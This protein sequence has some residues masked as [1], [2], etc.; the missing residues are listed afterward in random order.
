[1]PAD[2]FTQYTVA[3]P[4]YDDV[5]SHYEQ[6]TAALDA[7]ATP[8]EA[9]DVVCRWDAL[10]RSL[11]T[12]ST[13]VNIR[14]NQDTRNPDYITAREYSDEIAPKL[15]NLAVD[16]K[17]RLMASP[18]AGAI[19]DRVGRQ[20]FDLWKCDLASFDPII[21]EDLVRQSQLT[22][23]YTSLLAS[24]RFEF[25][26]ES[27][28][29]SEIIKFNEHPRRETRHA[30]ARTHWGWFTENQAQ[31]DS[32]FDQLVHLRDAMAKKL[33]Y[34]DFIGL[35][36]QRMQRVDYDQGDVERFRAE[37]REHVVPLAAEI[38][39]RQSAKL[40]ID[41]LMAWDEALHDPA[42]NPRPAG[43]HDWMIDRA[44]RMFADLSPPMRDF[45]EKM[46]AT[47]TMDLESRE[48]KAGGGFCDILPDFGMS[49]I[50]A[51]FNGTMYDVL[52]FTHEMGHAFQAYSSLS[53]LLSDYLFPTCEGAEI[54][55]IALE[56]LTWPSMELFFGDDAE[57]FRRTH[58]TTAL[59]FLP[60]GVAVDHFQHL[61]YSEPDASPDR[62][63]AIWQEMEQ[64]YLPWLNWGDLAHP[65]SGRRWQ[66]QRHIYSDP[67]YYI[68]YTLAQT[69]ALQLWVR[70]MD[71]RAGAME[72]YHELCRLGGSLPFRELVAAGGLKSPFE[73]GSLTEVVERASAELDRPLKGD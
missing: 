8:D 14:F 3:A 22:N 29:L 52:V 43:D 6:L 69:C 68:D 9:L 46:R 73:P 65:A 72:T 64:T 4:Q 20:A 25:E 13:L 17:R 16:M 33:G 51:N 38:R 24:A 19:A 31:L 40:G 58:L 35:G 48:G 37:V 21:E 62:R 36:Y 44:S 15:T 66:A 60:Y 27:L 57:R 2:D 39:R 70:A 34:D 54:H 45:F 55:S 53:H 10:R 42:G 28:T 61:V 41:P 59:L 18:F 23:E 71:D 63:A 5:A 30:A 56:F 67:F 49:F 50:Y 1:M 11:S 32:N 12:W 26:G 47:G 7:A